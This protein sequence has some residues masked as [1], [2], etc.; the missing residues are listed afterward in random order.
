MNDIV[1][2]IS[3]GEYSFLEKDRHGV[4]RR[5]D[6]K[7]GI[8]FN[9][10]GSYSI[11]K[12]WSPSGLNWSVELEIYLDDDT[13][14]EQTII[15]GTG[16]RVFVDGYVDQGTVTE[17]GNPILEL[18]QATVPL[19]RDM[20]PNNK[21]RMADTRWLNVSVEYDGTNITIKHGNQVTTTE[22][23]TFD[24]ISIKRIGSKSDGTGWMNGK[25]RQLIL[26]DKDT[27]SNSN[28][29]SAISQVGDYDVDIL[30]QYPD[31]NDS[32]L[33][34]VPPAGVSV[35]LIE[36]KITM[37][38]TQA[39]GAAV[40]S[41]LSSLAGEFYIV[42]YTIEDG[43]KGQI[44]IKVDGSSDSFKSTPGNYDDIHTITTGN[45]ILFQSG[46]VA[47]KFNGT[48]T[49][50]SIVEADAIKLFNHN[51]ENWYQNL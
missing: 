11:L 5:I 36:N 45:D 33:W 14:D 2:K 9:G 51:K 13:I 18:A 48:I 41:G 42:K 39:D 16:F 25:I 27:P 24:N 44:Q 50:I 20:V 22:A 37:D 26:T 35:N 3:G 38:G 43:S 28:H 15:E 10:V 34:G 49:I 47:D 29:Y 30:S 4:Y 31:L 17:K 7:V 23:L 8:D 40:T 19:T 12:E 46:S 21:E 6:R 1:K 32:S